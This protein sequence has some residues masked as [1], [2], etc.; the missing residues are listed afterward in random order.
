[1]AANHQKF[2]YSVDRDV[3]RPLKEFMSKNRE[4]QNLSTIQGNLAAMAKRIDSAADKVEKLKKRGAKSP[5]GKVAS[6]QSELEE[7]N[8]EWESQA[9][10]VFEN[11]QAVDEA[12]IN[13]LRDVLT[14]FQTHEVDQ[15]DQVRA[16]AEQCLNSLLALE[17]TDEISGFVARISA[18]RPIEGPRAGPASS[19]TLA[20]PLRTALS[21]DNA[22]QRSGL[23]SKASRPEVGKIYEGQC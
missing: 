14:Q 18:G 19:T 6:A 11:L 1:M 10:F 13:C 2:A 8:A 4:M 7:A 23:S 17:A 12:R 20:P 15:V 16:A 9:P 3:E 22:S 5:A 21:D